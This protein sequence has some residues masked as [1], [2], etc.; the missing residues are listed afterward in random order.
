MDGAA[1]GK[2]RF[3]SGFGCKPA[4][5]VSSVAQPIGLA[6]RALGLGAVGRDRFG[7]FAPRRP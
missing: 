2:R 1:L 7:G 4:Q 3:F 6:R 5:L